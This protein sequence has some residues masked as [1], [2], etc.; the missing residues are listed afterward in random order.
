MDELRI[1]LTGRK[2]LVVEEWHTASHLGSGG[3]PVYATPMMVLAMEEAALAAVDHLLGD[4]QATV[5][6]GLDVRHL[7]ATPLGMRVTATAE[8]V[9]AD[10]RM[11]TFRVEARDEVDLI[12][13][14]THVRAV[15]DLERFRDK[16]AKKARR[17]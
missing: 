6:V 5:G 2:E 8:L 11:L 16:L 10:G 4:G 12:G 15:V 9:G 14:G 3:A 13:E 7:A 17:A 1:G